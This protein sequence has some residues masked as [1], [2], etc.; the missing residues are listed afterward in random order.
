MIFIDLQMICMNR[1]ADETAEITTKNSIDASILGKF[2]Q[3]KGSWMVSKLASVCLWICHHG[4]KNAETLVAHRHDVSRGNTSLC[5]VAIPRGS[6]FK[7]PFFECLNWFLTVFGW[8]RLYLL[9][10]SKSLGFCDWGTKGTWFSSKWSLG[11]KLRRTSRGLA[12]T[13]SWSLWRCGCVR[14][15]LLKKRKNQLAPARSL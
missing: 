8:V 5:Q 9:R 1:T 2:A 13:V 6:L 12:M 3:M 7:P 15:I 4:S 14:C 11:S 10:L